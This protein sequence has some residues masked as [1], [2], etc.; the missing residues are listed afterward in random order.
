MKIATH[1][2]SI[3]QPRNI[4][5][6]MF[7]FIILVLFYDSLR[8]LLRLSLHS[9]EYSHI[10]L[11]PLISGYF[12]YQKRTALFETKEYSYIT[13]IALLITGSLLSLIGRK[14]NILEHN[15]YISLMISALL[16]LWIGGFIFFYGIR[17]Y[18]IASFPLLFLFLVVPVPSFIL[19]KIILFLQ[20]GSTEIA[21]IFLKITGISFIREGFVFHLPTMSV[22]VAQECSG[23]RSSIALFIM[24]ILIGA[25][26]LRT[27]WGRAIL[28]IAV[29]PLVIFKNG[30]RIVTLIMLAV[31]VDKAVITNSLLHKKGGIVF[32]LITLTFLMP[33]LWLIRRMEKGSGDKQT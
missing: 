32:F 11:I 20:M 12:L 27:G 8:D 17:S 28:M 4:F 2:Q 10:P 6:L 24:G 7:N 19:D 18:R 15:D 1:I 21:Y 16:I 22:E 9:P 31:Y 26:F 33:I 30:L 3:K 23:I 5:F 13:G 29:I 14:A 25:I